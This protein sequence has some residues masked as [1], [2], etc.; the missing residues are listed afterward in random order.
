[1]WLDWGRS[2]LC[3]QRLSDWRSIAGTA[4]ARSAHEPGSLFCAS[5]FTDHA[6]LFCGARNLLFVAVV[7]RVF[8]NVAAALEISSLRPEHRSSWR[9]GVLTRLVARGGR[10]ILSRAAVSVAVSLSPSPHRDH[11]SLPAGFSRPRPTHFFGCTESI[12]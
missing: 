9:D 7:A 4:R 11:H 6:C 5:S 3:P 1:V 8:R 10:P 2:F 12:S